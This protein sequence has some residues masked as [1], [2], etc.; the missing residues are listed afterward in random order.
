MTTRQFQLVLL[1]AVVIG[2]VVLAS[3]MLLLTT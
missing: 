1:V 2:L 3:R